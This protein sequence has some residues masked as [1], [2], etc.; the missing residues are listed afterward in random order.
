MAEVAFD[1]LAYSDNMQ[2]AGFSR[3]QADAMARA[4]ASALKDALATRELATRQDLLAARNELE[5]AIAKTR[6]DLEL[7]LAKTKNDLLKWVIGL[8]IAQT[9]LILTAFGIGIAY[10]R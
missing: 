5:T 1:T 9:S 3:E 10:L 4:N 8:I 2:K 6:H 7:A